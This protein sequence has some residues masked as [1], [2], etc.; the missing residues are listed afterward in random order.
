MSIVEY[1]AAIL[2]LG[3]AIAI[4]NGGWRRIAPLIRR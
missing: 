1:I 4:A 2:A 3:L